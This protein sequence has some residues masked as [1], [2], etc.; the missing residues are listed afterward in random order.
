MTDSLFINF[1]NHPSARWSRSQLSAAEAYGRVM[2]EPFPIV[3][4]DMDEAG[5]ARLADEAAERI[6]ARKPAAVLC[7]GEFTLAFA[8]TERLKAKGVTVLAASSDRVIETE[9]DENGETRKVSVFRF[10]RFRKY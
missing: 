4:A 1:S 2:D 7:Q 8:V 5:V 3:P 9:R 10:T 6:L